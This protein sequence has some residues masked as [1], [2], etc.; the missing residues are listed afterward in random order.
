MTVSTAPALLLGIGARILL[1]QFTRSNEPSLQA[2]FLVGVW[3]GVALW[4][5]YKQHN[6]GI[7]VAFGIAAK[8]YVEF[9]FTQDA[10]KPI[11]T[12]AGVALGVI[13]TE[14]LAGVFD[15]PKEK[16]S[17]KTHSTLANGH[18]TQDRDRERTSRHRRRTT[19]REP[20]RHHTSRHTTSDI[21]S[22]DSN[23][24]MIGPRG[25]MSPLD[26]EVVALRTRASLADSERRRFKEEK[27]WAI[28]Q[29]NTALASQLSWQIKRY[30]TLMK[31]FHREAD[32]KIIEASLTRAR[33]QTIDEQEP[34]VSTSERLPRR[35]SGKPEPPI[36]SVDIAQSKSGI[37]VNV[38]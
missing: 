5:A 37:R 25:S 24:E 20:Q 26:R 29:G 3:Q 4:Y 27:K 1:D 18:T 33:L 6:L 10:T 30:S 36:V 38:R 9:S 15:K 7:P 12:L 8:V 22:V 2:S 14:F 17:K 16:R 23:S 11:V 28:E 19:E 32:T 13:C 34:H 31:S 21:T 35:E